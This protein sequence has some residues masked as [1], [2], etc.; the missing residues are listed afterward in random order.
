MAKYSGAYK[1]EKRKKDLLRQ[2]KQ[3]EKRQRRFK[4]DVPIGEKDE[5]EPLKE[6]ESSR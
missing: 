4:K 3:E 1:S 5:A 2:E 6:T